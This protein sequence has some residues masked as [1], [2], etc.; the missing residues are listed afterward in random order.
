MKVLITGGSGFLG[1]HVVDQLI[2]KGHKVTVLDLKRSKFHNSKAYFLKC[3]LM[4]FKKLKEAV[5][6]KDIV[7]H[8]AAIANIDV[9]LKI[10]VETVYMNILGTVKL[11]EYCKKYKIK[12]FIFSSSVYAK[13]SDGGFYKSSKKSCEDYIEEYQKNFKLN[14]TI[15]RYG[16][17]YGPR[18]DNSNGIYKI[19]E[20]ALNLKKLIY[21]GNKK[22]KRKY[23]HVVDAAKAS[24]QVLSSNYKNKVINLVGKK[25]FKIQKLFLILKKVLKLPKEKKVNY[26]NKPFTGHYIKYPK[27]FKPKSGENFKFKKIEDFQKSLY[28]LKDTIKNEIKKSK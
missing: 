7:Y 22:A 11:L 20:D 26:L 25:T 21:I 3:N 18:S 16:S 10:P 27:I 13:S 5:K 6:G 8:F 14:Y 1:S 17:L 2:N 4:N 28:N 19:I 24:V 9:A 23:I 12:R 15:L